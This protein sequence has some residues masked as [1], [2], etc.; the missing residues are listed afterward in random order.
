M[1]YILALITKSK[2]QPNANNLNLPHFMVSILCLSKKKL[3]LCEL[4]VFLHMLCLVSLLNN[5]LKKVF[6]AKYWN[7]CPLLFVWGLEDRK[8]ILGQYVSS[9][10]GNLNV[11]WMCSASACNP[12]I[13]V[14]PCMATNRCIA[15]NM[16]GHECL[17]HLWTMLY[18]LGPVCSGLWL[19]GDD[20]KVIQ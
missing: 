6:E 18:Q 4:K 9:I 17:N 1:N 11:F 5:Y 14:Q 20:C 3:H 12:H 10:F 7:S 2:T 13:C 8:S 15:W 16:N 19:P